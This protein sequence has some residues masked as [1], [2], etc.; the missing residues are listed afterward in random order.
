MALKDLVRGHV[1]L[2]CQEL[3]DV[4]GVLFCVGEVCDLGA[5]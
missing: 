3:E 2:R 5:V 4:L 1:Q